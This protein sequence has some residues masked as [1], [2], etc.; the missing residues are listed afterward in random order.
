MQM[1]ERTHINAK[2][3]RIIA[4]CTH[5]HLLGDFRIGNLKYFYILN[6]RSGG[7]IRSATAQASLIYT[8]IGVL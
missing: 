4:F 3:Y 6:R 1:F 8:H 7:S 5:T 2:Y